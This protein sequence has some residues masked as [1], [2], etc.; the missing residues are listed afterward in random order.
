M[1][2]EIAAYKG[3]LTRQ[4][5]PD[6]G[7]QFGSRTFQH[8]YGTCREVVVYYDPDDETSVDVAFG[9]ESALPIHW[10]AEALAELQN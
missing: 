5:G 8:N 6:S 7:V 4:F 3:Q 1:K 9:V 10:D 2:R